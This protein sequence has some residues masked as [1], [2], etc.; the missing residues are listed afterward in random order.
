VVERRSKRGKTFYGCNRYPDCDFVAWGK[1]VP[2]KC[3]DCGSGYLIEK[4]LKS[5]A[6]A[7][8]P[9]GECKFKKPLAVPAPV[10]EEAA[11]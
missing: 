7:Q 8:C 6:F 2:E 5:G 10:P 1:P 4:F 11:V 3:P 9:N